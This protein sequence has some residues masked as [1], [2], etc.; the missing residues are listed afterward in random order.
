MRH[1]LGRSEL[2]EQY[3]IIFVQLDLLSSFSVNWQR[4]I[5]DNIKNLSTSK[6]KM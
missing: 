2:H 5:N 3:L 6:Q 4:R 1:E